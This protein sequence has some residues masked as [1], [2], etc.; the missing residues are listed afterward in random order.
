MDAT[1]L[2]AAITAVAGA[3][4]AGFFSLVGLIVS[5]DIKTSDARLAWNEALREKLSA[6]LG[7]VETI[8][9][10]AESHL[11]TQRVVDEFTDTDLDKFRDRHK[12]EYLATEIARHKTVM[13]LNPKEKT[14]LACA[15]AIDELFK[16]FYGKRVDSKK[17]HS[18]VDRVAQEGGEVLREVWHVVRYG[19]FS[20]RAFKWIFFVIFLVTWLSGVA[21]LWSSSTEPAKPAAST[22]ASSPAK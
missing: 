4:L 18:L 11:A 22:Q 14:H 7:R 15:K 9:R 10:L 16:N 17:V 6:M 20:Y 1:H 19:E 12:E 2:L 13:R 5:K 21:Y 3:I 8:T